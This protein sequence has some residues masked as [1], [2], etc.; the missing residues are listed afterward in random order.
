MGTFTGSGSVNNSVGSITTGVNKVITISS[1]GAT[2]YTLTTSNTATTPAT[3]TANVTI[4]GYAAPVATSLTAAASSITNGNSTTITPVFSNGTGK[5]GTTSGGS[6]VTASATSGVAVTV[7]PSSNTTYYLTVTNVPGSTAST[8]TSITVV[9]APV[10]TSLIAGSSTLT[11]GSST[12]LTPVFSNGTGKIGTTAGGSQVTSSATSGTAVTVSPPSGATTTYYLT[13]TNSLGSI[14][15]TSTSITTV[16]SPTISSFVS[17]KSLITNGNSLTLTPTFSNGTGKIGTSA[18][19]SDVTSSATSGAAVTVSPTSTTTYYLTVTN[20]AGTSVSSNLTITVKPVPTASLTA[21]AYQATAGATVITL[22]PT[23]SGASSGSATING[24]GAVTSASSYNVVPTTEPTTSYTLTVN[25]GLSD[26]GST[27]TSTVEITVAPFP[28]I[29]SVTFGTSLLLRGSSTTI[30]PTFSGGT[31]KIGTTAGGNEITASATSGVGISISPTITTTYYLTVTNSIG[32]SQD[33]TSTLPVYVRPNSFSSPTNLT[34]ITD[35]SP[36]D[37]TTYGYSESEDY[38]DFASLSVTGTVYIKYKKINSSA[39]SLLSIN[40]YWLSEPVG[41]GALLKYIFTL[42]G[43]ETQI[44]AVSS[45]DPIDNSMKSYSF[46]FSG[47]LSNL[48]I[49]VG[50]EISTGYYMNCFIEG[51][52]GCLQ[53]NEE[54]VEASNVA[55]FYIYDVYVVV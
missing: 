16:V 45:G 34:N 22:Y 3:T 49:K 27:A 5:I 54:P 36:G 43:L 41:S 19:G 39:S 2:T 18:G 53:Y 17:N 55:G 20:A 26:T 38:I 8:S 33:T 15:S 7:S 14:A 50:G 46:P 11:N 6:Q 4:T 48:R 10:A 28:Q 37:E 23:Y 35:G 44:A 12:S 24:I 29:Q 1:A 25:N 52:D 30:I 31:L 47:D 21:S 13:V 32:Y 40:D 51:Y 9:A 42:S